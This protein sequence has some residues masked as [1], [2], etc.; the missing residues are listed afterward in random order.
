MS[1]EHSFSLHHSAAEYRD[2]AGKLRELARACVFPGPRRSLLQL[3]GSFDYRATHFDCR[4][5]PEAAPYRRD[6]RMDAV[7]T[8]LALNI[9]N[10]LADA[11]TLAIGQGQ[12]RP[13]TA[14]IARQFVSASLASAAGNWQGVTDGGWPCWSFVAPNLT[15]RREGKRPN[16][17]AVK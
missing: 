9:R 8:G 1:D 5:T 15:N 13:A 2:L 4:T 14:R 10:V 7:G 16:H 11:Q 12:F 17:L 6:A 3:A